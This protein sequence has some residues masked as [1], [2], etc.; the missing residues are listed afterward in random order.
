MEPL[1]T[2]IDLETARR[3][4]YVVNGGGGP[5]VIAKNIE[6]FAAMQGWENMLGRILETLRPVNVPRA[7]KDTKLLCT[8]PL[9]HK[10]AVQWDEV[11]DCTTNIPEG[12]AIL[13][14]LYPARPETIPPSQVW[15]KP[16]SVINRY[17]VADAIYTM[18]QCGISSLAYVVAN[19][20]NLLQRI[21]NTDVM[22]NYNGR[23]ADS[24]FFTAIGGLGET[25]APM[26]WINDEYEAMQ[27]HAK[28]SYNAASE[29]F[30]ST[31]MDLSDDGYLKHFR[32]LEEEFDTQWKNTMLES[33]ACTVEDSQGERIE[34]GGTDEEEEGVARTRVSETPGVVVTEPVKEGYVTTVPYEMR[35]QEY[36]SMVR[37]TTQLLGYE[38]KWM[39]ILKDYA[40]PLKGPYVSTTRSVKQTQKLT[41]CFKELEADNPLTW[42]LKLDKATDIPEAMELGASMLTWVRNIYG[43][44]AP[45]I[46]Q[47][48]KLEQSMRNVKANYSASGGVYNART[49]R[50]LIGVPAHFITE[51]KLT[52]LLQK[53]VD[54]KEI[55]AIKDEAKYEKFLETVQERTEAQVEQ[56][57]KTTKRLE[58]TQ[59]QTEEGEQSRKI[60]QTHEAESR[61][62]P[63]P[64]AA[65][66]SS[67]G[68][69]APSQ[70]NGGEDPAS[71]AQS[72]ATSAEQTSPGIVEM[73][74]RAEQPQE[75]PSPQ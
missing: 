33:W 46:K 9:R 28:G 19:Q 43:Q 16:T 35:Q 21:V 57:L 62:E 69:A 24:Q 1:V 14:E 45:Q 48:V 66:A 67:F 30:I 61:T 31:Q 4:E 52:E 39:T 53:G 71:A 10:F 70:A 63:I 73:R 49:F 3:M 22:L 68:G 17:G 12:S 47:L 42:P 7:I 23:L 15:I 20:N 40:W 6:D 13:S 54:P 2:K 58:F 50:E 56:A 41:A 64:T 5:T 75:Q 11:V 65:P 27:L 59:E 32:M 36:E 38:P 60:L 8:V 44:S 55:L 25:I 37:R 29:W 51:A 18:L 74:F 26:C 34:D 72:T